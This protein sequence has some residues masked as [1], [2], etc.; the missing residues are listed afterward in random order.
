[1]TPEAKRIKEKLERKEVVVDRKE[2]DKVVK[3]RLDFGFDSIY[4]RYAEV[5]DELAAYQSVVDHVPAHEARKR[6][7]GR[8]MHF[9]QA[10]EQLVQ[11]H[12]EREDDLF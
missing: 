10:L 6:M 4:F 5:C 1:M 3:D 7:N 11:A 8:K 2:L 12:P 9:Y